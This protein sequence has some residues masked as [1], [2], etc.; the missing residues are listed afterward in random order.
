MAH[1]AGFPPNIHFSSRLLTESTLEGILMFPDKIYI[2]QLSLQVIV[3]ME[4]SS[5]R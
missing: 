5:G 3:A 1:T 4:H 2:S